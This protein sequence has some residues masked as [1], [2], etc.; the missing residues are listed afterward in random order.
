MPGSLVTHATA[1][2]DGRDRRRGERLC[3]YVARPP[4][5]QE[6]LQLLPDGRLRFQMKKAWA[7][8]TAAL[9]FEPLSLIA[10]LRALVPPPRF[11]M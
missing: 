6:R 3:R 8:G 11:H 9:V 2:I 1:A 10:R 5:A 7:D 4:I